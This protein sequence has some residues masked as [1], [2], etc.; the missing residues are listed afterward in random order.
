MQYPDVQARR[1][2]LLIPLHEETVRFVRPA[3]RALMGAVGFVLLI[4]CV[5]VANLL[6]AR[7]AGRRREVAIRMALGAGRFRL[8]MIALRGE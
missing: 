5:N 3:L 2:V 7:A 1:S 6:L 8:P 4:A